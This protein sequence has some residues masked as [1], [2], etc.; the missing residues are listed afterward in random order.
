MTAE[1]PITVLLGALGGQGGGVLADW[2]SVAA[3]RAG[4]PGLAAAG[5]AMTPSSGSPA[6][7]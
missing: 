7:E 4:F 6:R 5:F 1:R 2:L 3:E